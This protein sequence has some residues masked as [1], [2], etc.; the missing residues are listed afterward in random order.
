MV[1]TFGLLQA[2][3]SLI[4]DSDDELLCIKAG[5]RKIVYLNRSQLYFVCISSMN[6]PE[7]IM[8]QQLLF[9]YYQILSVLTSQLHDMLRQ[10]SKKDLRDLLGSDTPLLLDSTCH[11][12][13]TPFSI[14][15]GAVRGYPILQSIRVDTL[16]F[17]R[18][19]V[20]SSN[21]V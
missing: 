2:V 5:N 13:V 17:L 20:E 7:A 21:A 15:T 16:A 10:N 19:C 8:H 1:T 6:E 3:I 11:E 18:R 12:D 9:M 4:H 14:G